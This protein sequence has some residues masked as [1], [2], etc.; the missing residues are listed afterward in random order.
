M[1]MV[2]RN[3]TKCL[4]R[5]SQVCRNG[6]LK[7]DQ[8][9]NS[10]QIDERIGVR[11]NLST[12]I[13]G[14]SVFTQS[15]PWLFSN[16]GPKVKLSK[17]SLPGPRFSRRSGNALRIMALGDSGGPLCETRCA[18]GHRSSLGRS[19]HCHV[20]AGTSF[21]RLAAETLV[22]DQAACIA[23]SCADQ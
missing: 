22:S 23:G 5:A 6:R 1:N 8:E 10:S 3:R 13:F 2:V 14:R 4:I 7:P 9:F 15:R 20:P 21:S 16:S 17:K 18:M 19:R 11:E 12:R